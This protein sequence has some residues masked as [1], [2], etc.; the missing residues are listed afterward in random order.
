M[1]YPNVFAITGVI[2]SGK[3]TVAKLLREAGETVLDADEYAKFILSEHYQ[4]YPELVQELKQ[5]FGDQVIHEG[6]INRK[7]LGELVFANKQKLEELNQ[8]IHPRVRKLFEQDL[9]QYKGKRIFYDVPLLF[10][11]N[12]QNDFA[13]T[14]VVYAPEEIAI[15]RAANRLGLTKDQVKE[16]MQNQISI[17]KKKKLADYVI[18]NTQGMAELKEQ[19]NMLLQTLEN[20]YGT[21]Q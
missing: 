21:K 12:M 17:E 6:K 15:Q 3:S 9:L 18:E 11:K 7:K 13:A 1:K 8:L 2:G 14:I 10:E 20:K 5:R 19:V 16:R 4:E